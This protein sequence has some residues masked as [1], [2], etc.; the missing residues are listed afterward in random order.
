MAVQEPR[1]K[2]KRALDNKNY[3]LNYSIYNLC[4]MLCFCV[5]FLL[6][7][8]A[9]KSFKFFLLITIYKIEILKICQC[10][11]RDYETLFKNPRLDILGGKQ[12]NFLLKYIFV[13]IMRQ[14]LIK[15]AVASTGFRINQRT[16][17]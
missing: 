13:Q 17:N 10:E 6:F 1:K 11:L 8:F 3:R 14:N 15:K 12:L 5:S 4:F 9:F 2:L 7:V 16:S